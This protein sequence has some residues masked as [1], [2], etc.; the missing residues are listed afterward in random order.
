MMWNIICN[1]PSFEWAIAFRSNPVNQLMK[2][3]MTDEYK[4]K[5]PAHFM[6][7]FIGQVNGVWTYCGNTNPLYFDRDLVK[8]LADLKEW[9]A[10]VAQHTG[11]EWG[12]ALSDTIAVRAY[13]GLQEGYDRKA[14][15][16]TV[17]GLGLSQMVSVLHSE[18]TLIYPHDGFIH[19]EPAI[20]VDF[21]N[22]RERRIA[23]VSDAVTFAKMAGEQLKQ[24]RVYVQDQN[25]LLIY[26]KA[27]E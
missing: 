3:F 4:A 20:R 11:A 8:V 18:G 16:G 17:F 24:K 13:I 2:L 15:I 25:F 19:S 14:T 9:V 7:G 1:Q 26:Q 23:S 5:F 22:G 6:A 12:R 10:Y 27:T 21:L